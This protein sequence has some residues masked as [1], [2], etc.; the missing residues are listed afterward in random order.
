MRLKAIRQYRGLENV[1]KQ[2]MRQFHSSTGVVTDLSRQVQTHTKRMKRVR[3]F[4]PLHV[5]GNKISVFAFERPKTLKFVSAPSDYSADWG[6]ENRSH[7][8]PDSCWLHQA[9][10]GN[11]TLF[12]DVSPTRI[13]HTDIK[14]KDFAIGNQ[15]H[16]PI[17]RG[18]TLNSCPRFAGNRIALMAPP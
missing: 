4:N 9:I 5:L 6:H 14:S 7:D 16:T 1:R 3:I 17:A 2:A 18:R 15:T 13:D 12:Q 11:K 8:V 10:G